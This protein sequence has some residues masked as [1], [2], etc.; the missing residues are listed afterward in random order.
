M[1]HKEHFAAVNLTL[2]DICENKDHLFGGIPVVL[3]GD[4]AQTLPVVPRG[5]QGAQCNASISR[6]TL[7]SQLE[8]LRLKINMR[9]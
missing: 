3:G 4:F 6:S 8:V 1:Q 2:E 7:W 9:V 5:S